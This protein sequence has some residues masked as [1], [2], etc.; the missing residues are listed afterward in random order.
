MGEI[1]L[2]DRYPRSVRP[3]DERGSCITE[4]HRRVARRFG[5]EYFDGERLT[6]Y[7]GY[8]YHPRFWRD[9]VKRFVEFYGLT[10]ES[11]ILDV[12]CAKGYM[13]YEFKQLLPGLS[14][15]GID[16]SEYSIAKSP[17]AIRPYLQ[18]ANA[19]ELPF[20]D[21]EFDLVI[22]INTIHNLEL[23]ECK[24]ALK[25][26]KRVSKNHTFVTVDAWRNDM[27]RERL[28]KWNLTAL[29][30]MHAAD[31][32]LVLE[33]TGYSGDYYWFIADTAA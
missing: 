32:E 27:E 2:L 13:L 31:W 3:I 11:K 21:D 25:E 4:D 5:K 30:Y 29:T 28:L 9:T 12:G 33:E 17:E 20:A 14:I 16:I 24:Q 8:S 18:I 19:K 23:D 22:S 15:T 7:G 6:G 26:V 10:E 1:N